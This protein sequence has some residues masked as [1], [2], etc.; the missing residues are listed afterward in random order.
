MV[1]RVLNHYPLTAFLASIVYGSQAITEKRRYILWRQPYLHVRIRTITLQAKL[2]AAAWV[3]LSYRQHR[4]LDAGS[5]AVTKKEGTSLGHTFFFIGVTGF[6]PAAS[7]SRTKHSTGL[8][9]TPITIVVYHKCLILSIALSKV[10]ALPSLSKQKQ[11]HR[12]M[13][14]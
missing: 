13:T 1:Y 12:L 8:S 9:H 3:N 4:R 14:L 10:F 5:Q 6:E 2:R 7:W 11:S